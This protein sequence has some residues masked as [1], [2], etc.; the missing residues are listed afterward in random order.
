MGMNTK[1]RIGILTIHNS[2][3]YG[4]CLQA[5]ALYTYLSQQTDVFCEII[6]LHRPHEKGYIASK[7]FKPYRCVQQNKWKR[8]KAAL[9]NVIFKNR[10]TDLYSVEA[11]SKFDAF[12]VGIKLSRPYWSID[13]L[14]AC[15]PDYDIYVTG[16]DQVWNPTQPYCLEPYFLTFAPEGKKKISY[17]SSIAVTE[18]EVNEKKDFQHWLADYDIISVRERNARQLLESFI[19]KPVTLV[20]DPTFLLDAEIWKALAVNP[21]NQSPYILLF[22]LDFNLD[23]LR[24]ALRVNKDAGL[25]LIYLN[26]LA[27]NLNGEK[28]VAIRDAGPKEFLGYI[29]CADMVITDSYHAT[30]FSVILEAKN[31]STYIAEYNQRGSRITDLLDTFGL[32]QHLL[33]QDLSEDYHTLSSRHIDWQRIRQVSQQERNCGREFLKKAL[34]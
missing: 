26:Q 9:R 32:Q 34:S 5:Y 4:A 1:K 21:Q 29:A 18:L 2:P 20:A 11:K 8:I 13:E 30:V 12:N 10:K 25:C 6:D 17:A 7:R 27:P 22:T 3:N 31:F 15:P 28:C 16:S 33:R 23:L 24:F 19:S 14:Y